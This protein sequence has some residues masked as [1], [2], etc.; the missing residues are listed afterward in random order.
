MSNYE[1]TLACLSDRLGGAGRELAGLGPGPRGRRRRVDG[2]HEVPVVGAAAAVPRRIV[3]GAKVVADLV[4]E[5]V[6]GILKMDRGTI[7]I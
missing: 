4:R 3:G 5:G 7:H 1:C 2:R 6:L